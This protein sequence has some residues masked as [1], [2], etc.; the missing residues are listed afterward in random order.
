MVGGAYPPEVRTVHVPMFTSDDFRRGIEFQLTEA[1]QKQIQ[2]RTPFRLARAEYAD[3]VLRGHLANARKDLLVENRFDDPRALQF[4]LSLE[5]TW[6]DV[7]TG[8]ILAE[9]RIPIEP[10]VIPLVVQADFAPELGQSRATALDE[11]V[12][13]MADQIVDLMEAPW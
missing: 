7:R 3:T 12:Q 10:Q 11:A 9:Q 4:T 13:R 1:V 2:S 6:E 8:R 5:V